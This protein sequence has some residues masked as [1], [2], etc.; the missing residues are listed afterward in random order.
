[1]GIGIDVSIGAQLRTPLPTN[2]AQ[3]E[4]QSASDERPA[5]PICENINRVK[6]NN[7]DV[8]AR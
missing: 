1:M 7:S 6:N 4:R 8:H 5:D 3:W 2:K